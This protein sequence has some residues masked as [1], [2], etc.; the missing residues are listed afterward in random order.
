M[1]IHPFGDGN[2][3]VGRIVSSLPL[4]KHN[5]PPVVVL[6]DKKD[7]YFNTLLE[8]DCSGKYDK[9]IRLMNFQ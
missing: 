9:K 5:L 8:A 2:G 6:K 3:R 4:I 7:Q 1:V